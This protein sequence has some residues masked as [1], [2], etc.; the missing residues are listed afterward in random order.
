MF[1]AGNMDE[2]CIEHH[3]D[4]EYTEHSNNNIFRLYWCSLAVLRTILDL[5]LLVGQ[6]HQGNPRL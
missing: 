1:A 4:L 2:V 6:L 5:E 3:M